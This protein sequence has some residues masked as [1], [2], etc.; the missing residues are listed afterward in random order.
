M[1]SSVRIIKGTVLTMYIQNC[2]TTTQCDLCPLPSVVVSDCGWMRLELKT[3]ATKVAGRYIGATTVNAFS[4][5]K[6]SRP[7]L[8]IP[9]IVVFS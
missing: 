1:P 8:A 9:A 4:I 6:S 7:Y 5:S 2:G 3:V